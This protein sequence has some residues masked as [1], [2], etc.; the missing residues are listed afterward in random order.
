MEVDYADVVEYVG[1]IDSVKVMDFVEDVDYVDL[2]GLCGPGGLSVHGR[3]CEGGTS[4]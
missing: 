3:I 1:E 4:C 2:D